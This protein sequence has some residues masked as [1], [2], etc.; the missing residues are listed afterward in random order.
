MSVAL[1][2]A[3]R[4]EGRTRPNPPVGAVVFQ[5]H[6]Q[7]NY[8]ADVPIAYVYAAL[9]ID[10]RVFS[11]L[12]PGDQAIVREVMEGIYRKFDKYGVSDNEE[13][14]Q[15][16]LA[17]GLEPITPDPADVAEWREVVRASHRQLASE[18][19][20]DPAL[21]EQIESSLEQYRAGQ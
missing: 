4:G 3:R 16:L 10:K 17:S 5:W 6:T 13:A 11:K 7:V 21:Y 14:M 8:L 18:Q 15:A 20:F 12:T 2:H 19:V 1:D 9:L